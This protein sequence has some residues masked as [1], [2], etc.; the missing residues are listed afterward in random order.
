MSSRK[1]TYMGFGG[2]IGVILTLGSAFVV[3]LIGTD[4]TWPSWLLPLTAPL[5]PGGI[6]LLFIKGDNRAPG[7]IWIWMLP[8]SIV[9]NAGVGALTGFA[10]WLV[11]KSARRTGRTR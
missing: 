5:G 2:A 11:V 10:V 7:D 6:V 3:A 9:I 8:M 4:V 1:A